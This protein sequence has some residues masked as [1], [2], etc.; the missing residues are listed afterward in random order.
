MSQSDEECK[1]LNW[2]GIFTVVNRPGDMEAVLMC[3]DCGKLWYSMVY[4]RM[5]FSDSKDVFE[6]YQIPITMEEFHR[7]KGIKYEELN[8]K[9][10]K[11]RRARVFHESGVGEVDSDFALRR[12]GKLI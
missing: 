12:C 8:Y 2:K 10:L 1:C 6:E 5:S 4:E 7:I 11:G 3:Q 9:F